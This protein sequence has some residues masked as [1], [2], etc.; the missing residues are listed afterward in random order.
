MALVI[1][2]SFGS[3]IAQMEPA[4][5]AE[6]QCSDNQGHA[7]GT[8]IR[9]RTGVASPR[10]QSPDACLRFPARAGQGP[11]TWYLSNLRVEAELDAY[12]AEGSALL[13]F[14]VN[15]WNSIQLDLLRSGERELA[16]RLATV[17]GVETPPLAISDG[18]QTIVAMKL[19]NYLQDRSVRAGPATVRAILTDRGA[20]VRRVNVVAEVRSTE[21]PPYPLTIVAAGSSED[22][23]VIRVVVGT[24]ES[25]SNHDIEI[26]AQSE[27]RRISLG[28]AT[29]VGGHAWEFRMRIPTRSERAVQYGVHVAVPRLA[30]EEDVLGAV[31]AVATGSDRNL[32][33]VRYGA[34]AL[35][36][37]LLLVG[38]RSTRRRRS[39]LGGARS[40][41]KGSGSI[42][43]TA[44]RPA[45]SESVSAIALLVLVAFALPGFVLSIL[46][47]SSGDN[48]CGRVLFD[49]RSEG[50]CRAPIEN[51]TMLCLVFAI[52]G[53]V[54][55][56]A[57]VCY[58]R[59]WRLLLS[60]TAASVSLGLLLF[61]ANRMLQ[62]TPV[63]SI[64]CGSAV[65]P[66][67]PASHRERTLC[68]TLHRSA[69]VE[70]CAALVAS[71]A[72]GGFAHRLARGGW[73]QRSVS[74]SSAEPT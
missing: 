42:S 61:G 71:V 37:V 27:G 43:K 68:A 33:W 20:R 63:A 70:A 5:A 74:Q 46:A 6:S 31:P 50:A 39:G 32:G 38:L 44:E 19:S 4:D 56:S 17:R 72:A 28:S 15:D 73:S 48:Y 29:R 14:Q 69:T 51:R 55:A 22:P 7:L 34:G 47:V 45:P 11:S 57:Y 23:S 58:T 30:L 54:V 25:V 59:R 1:V 49:S 53:V 21:I 65:R 16:A 52:T 36:F 13:E 9:L 10:S 8:L 35:G 3:L 60:L 2:S 40:A 62:P 18:G 24:Q 41:H 12:A 67:Q 64:N 66:Y 26:G